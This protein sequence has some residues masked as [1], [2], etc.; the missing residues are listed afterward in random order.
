MSVKAYI[1]RRLVLMIF[2]LFGMT[3]ITFVVA[4]VVPSDPAATYVGGLARPADIAR[5]RVTLGLNRS[6]W[7]Q[8][9]I[10]VKDLVTGNWGISL[11][12][13][14]PV[15]SDIGH[16]LPVS[17]QLIILAMVLATCSGILVGVIAGRHRGSLIDNAVRPLSIVGV[18][19]PA[20]GIAIVLQLLFCRLL[21][22]LPVAGKVGLMVAEQHPITH[23]TGLD[24]VDSLVTGNL[25]GFWDA[26]R[27][28]VLPV[29]AVAAYPGGVIM[30]MTRSTTIETLN[31]EYVRMHKAMGLSMRKITF[32]YA[33]KNALGPVTTVAG[34][35]FAY[36]LVGT[37]LVEV[38]FS[39]P[40]LGMY[41][42]NAVMSLDYPVVL[43][44]TIFVAT[45]YIVV[46]L[47]VDLCVAWL[48][49]RIILGR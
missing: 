22:V 26:L 37:F 11:V 10:Y 48:D 28:T 19:F 30:R 25:T 12:S 47:L 4:R 38:V 3:V 18:S 15:L 35:E 42:V 14:R 1:L 5:A 34:I 29:L 17:L 2:I 24:L 46:N 45:M 32:K 16:F 7:V 6:L 39:Y 8:Y 33:L 13:K 27:H 44:T 49:P 41:T 36:A 40:G 20:F 23:I 43:G 9:G 31:Q 21:N